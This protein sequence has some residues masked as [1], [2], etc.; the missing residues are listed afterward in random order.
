MRRI[1][2]SVLYVFLFLLFFSTTNAVALED[3]RTREISTLVQNIEVLKQQ[4]SYADT[5]LE[6][7]RLEEKL[8]E[9]ELAF[10]D[11]A[12]DS[13]L[14]IL[15]DEYVVKDKDLWQ[16]FQEVLKPVVQS[17]KRASEKPRRI[18]QIRNS[19]SDLEQKIDDAQYG[20]SNIDELIK[21]YPSGVILERLKESRA[22]T[23]KIEQELEIER[24]SLQDQ[25]N[26]ELKD[27]K[28]F[29]STSKLLLSD[30]FKNKGKNLLLALVISVAT[31]WVLILFKKFVIR[32][33]L[34]RERFYFISK[35]FL[36]LYGVFAVLVS[37]CA[38]LL[39]LFLLNDWFLFIMLL[40]IIGLVFWGFKHLFVSL[41]SAVKIIFDLGT[42]REGQR[43]IFDSCPWLVKKIGLQTILENDSLR[44]G[45]IRVGINRIKDLT[46]RPIIAGEPWFPTEQGDY[47][48][49]EDGTYGKVSFQSPEQVV[50]SVKGESKKFYTVSA[51]IAQKPK[52][53]S[54]G[55]EISASID[56][57]YSLQSNI[58]DVLKIFKN[59]LIL[60]LR[61]HKLST[62]VQR[63]GVG[64]YFGGAK[65]SSLNIIAE[66]RFEGELAPY[67]LE[68]KR[69]VDLILVIICTDNKFSIP[70][71]QLSVHIA[72]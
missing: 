12:T 1:F 69:E 66:V 25:L 13:D 32:P 30:F 70:Y 48:I 6:K 58:H 57:D 26:E 62:K 50:I 33:L 53:L 44:G 19:I 21:Q 72:N 47:V 56:I 71:K 4:I 17:L 11:V 49:L 60:K 9:A 52:N 15:E 27:N 46:S 68:L 24:E 42:V 22:R 63:K 14:F 39:C 10:D 36:A 61:E 23:V 41:F 67:Y 5:T 2:I 31:F 40:L 8:K 34:H 38:G 35:P 20:L 3:Q 59:N 28:S 55:F 65:E 43:I 16:E 54:H 37:I 7:E 45:E 18:E 29:L 64:V 51:F